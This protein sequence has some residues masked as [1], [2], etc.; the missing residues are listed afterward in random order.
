[1]LS[2]N[3]L[4]TKFGIVLVVVI[5]AVLLAFVLG[6]LLRNPQQGAQ[7]PTVGKVDGSKVRYSEFNAAYQ[8]VLALNGNSNANYDMSSQ[9][10]SMTWESILLGEV[11]LPGME[12]LG[13]IY[14]P[15][16]RE[17]VLK[18]QLSSNVLDNVF[19]AN[20]KYDPA[21]LAM[22]LEYAEGDAQ[23]QQIWNL[24]EEQVHH[25]R[26]T[27]KYMDL[28]RCGAYANALMLND[29]VVA[30]NNTY[31]GHYVACNYSSVAD[32]LVSVSDR[33]IKKYYEAN[34]AKFRQN[35]YRTVRYAHFESEP[36]EKDK[37]TIEA[38]AKGAANLFR[39]TK[40]LEA[41]VA[42]NANTSIAQN[43]VSESSLSKEEAAA[44]RGGKMYGPE[45]KGDSWYASRLVEAIV[46]PKSLE[47]Q[48][49]AL[50]KSE[51]HL[52]DSLYKAA[53]VPGANF[54]T[55]APQGSY[56]DLGEMQFSM[57]PVELAKKL[58][59][60]KANE[61]VKIEL[62]GSIQI[63]K[64]SK[65]GARERHLRLATQTHKVFASKETND[66]LYK[67]ACDFARKAKNEG[68]D[69]AAKSVPTSS[70]NVTK[71]SRNVPGLAN[72]V[73]VVRWANEAKV[74]DMSEI[75]KI[76]ESY[77]V[78]I[79]TAVEES[80]YEPIEKA[81]TK[82][83]PV[84]MAQKKAAILKEKMQGATLEEIAANAG[85]TVKE[86][87]GV[88]TSSSFISGIGMEPSVIGTLEGVTAEG[89][90]KPLPLV[91]GKNGVYALV[92]D[93]VAVEATQTV[94]AERVKAQAELES[95]AGGRAMWAAKEA[96]NIEDNTVKFF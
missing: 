53:K 35:P 50:P 18:G 44:L 40:N 11:M 67:E 20:G 78:A 6:D 33:E 76:G 12:K 55:V 79:V 46:A 37:K 42:N 13:L 34:K 87:S 92:V 9:L 84:L 49:I 27:S 36:S 8:N 63:L 77:V 45:L 96:A 66:A 14:A 88:K 7:N 28:V 95:M 61:V 5:G 82:I 94:E 93:E 26:V 65:V 15:A 70:M 17:A 52:A 91:E 58:V 39:E 59:N 72:S 54:A 71:G 1:M 3:N 32:S 22:F 86:F 56:A 75:I 68:F 73:E 21:M 64:V 69:E 19:G 83:K 25:D 80:E 31:K 48:Q 60:A 85:A 89:A 4:R 23:R 81:T 16:E 74:G 43:Y 62:G 51:S 90:G 10:I 24:L 30:Q 57:L 41:Y 29:G 38:A 2:L 47:L